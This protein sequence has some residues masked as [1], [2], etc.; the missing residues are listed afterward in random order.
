MAK[1]KE[2]VHETPRLQSFD[3]ALGRVVGEIQANTPDEVRAAVEH[4]R[5]AF[6][7]WAALPVKQRAVYLK[8]V[9]HRIFENLDP[10]LETIRPKTASLGPKPSRTMSSR[11]SSHCNTWRTLRRS[12]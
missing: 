3:P 2:A 12:R 5:K 11:R 6:P 9:R 8:E 10:I 1:A 7:D 4:A